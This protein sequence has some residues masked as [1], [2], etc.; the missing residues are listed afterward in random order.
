VVAVAA[1]DWCARRPL[2]RR[3][4][5]SQTGEPSRRG[6][7]VTF[8]DLV[9]SR[10][11]VLVKAWCNCSG[12]NPTA[13]WRSAGFLRIGKRDL[14]CLTGTTLM[15][16]AGTESITT[17]AAPVKQDLRN[18]AARR[19]A[20][21]DR[22][23]VELADDA[24]VVLDDGADGQRLDRGGVLAQRLD[25]QTGIRRGENAVAA[26]LVVRDPLLSQLRGESPRS[27]GSGRW[28]RG[29]SDR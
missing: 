15:P 17:P 4:T 13:L 23:P 20:H 26:P 6:D 19:V 27:R 21:D 29:R 28:C 3:Q 24:L 12:V 2:P 1:S 22:G 7:V 8:V 10:L 16:S 14:I 9:S 18:Q 11:R 5:R 25:L